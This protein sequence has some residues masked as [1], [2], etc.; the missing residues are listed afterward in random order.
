MI[1]LS[2]SFQRFA[3]VRGYLSNYKFNINGT[4]MKIE[5]FPEFAR[6]EISKGVFKD[7]SL[8]NFKELFLRGINDAGK[9]LSEEL[10]LPP[11]CFYSKVSTQSIKLICYYPGKVTQVKYQDGLKVVDFTI[12]LPN[13]VIFFDIRKE[14]DSYFVSS[15]EVKYFVTDKTVDQI[16]SKSPEELRDILKPVPFTNFYSNGRMCFGKNTMPVKFSYNLR[17]LDYYYKIIAISP[18]NDDLGV[19][20]MKKHYSCYSL[21]TALSGKETF[22]YG[23]MQ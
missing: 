6:I 15:D 5:L 22:P 20:G 17:G 10:I 18:F 3:D 7:I 12:P 1:P 19:K 2:D 23:D 4:P 13:M 9:E 21:F 8:E 16:S 14:D 11:G